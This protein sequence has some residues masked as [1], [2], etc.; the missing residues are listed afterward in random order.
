ML[1]VRPH[2]CPARLARS[3]APL[4]KFPEIPVHSRL[5]LS[6]DQNKDAVEKRCPG[7]GQPG[8]K[9]IVQTAEYGSPLKRAG[10]THSAEGNIWVPLSI[11]EFSETP[12]RTFLL[13]AAT[14]GILCL[15][16]S[17][18]SR[19]KFQKVLPLLPGTS[20]RETLGPV[21]GEPLRC[22]RGV[23]LLP[24]S[25]A[26]AAPRAPQQPRA[27]THQ[28]TPPCLGEP[29]PGEWVLLWPPH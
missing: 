7:S 1:H 29:E 6:P 18:K 2:V 25:W 11:P 5:W 10:S 15:K 26:S 22:Q 12:Q 9:I 19:Q 4:P 27:Q 8:V 17:G 13:F 14:N 28:F 20:W 3:A 24:L 16:V 21:E 23:A